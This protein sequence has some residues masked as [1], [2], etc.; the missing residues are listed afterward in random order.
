ME[1]KTQG[2]KPFFE[3]LWFSVLVFIRFYTNTALLYVRI[4]LIALK[5]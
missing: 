5:H 1:Y 2:L 4:F 3:E